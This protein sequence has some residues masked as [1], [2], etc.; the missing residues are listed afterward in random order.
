MKKKNILIS[1]L[2]VTPFFLA[3]CAS[4][5]KV[6]STDVPTA[7]FAAITASPASL[8]ETAKHS[9]ST[10]CWLIIDGQTYNI[11]PYVQSGMHPGGEKILAGCGKD[12]SAMFH[13]ISKHASPHSQANLEKYLVK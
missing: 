6:A 5:K 1:L 3:A 8:A 9:T 10:D 12:A 7:S 4:Q 11:T 13:S 2:V